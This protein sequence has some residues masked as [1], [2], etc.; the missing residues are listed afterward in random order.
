MIGRSLPAARVAQDPEIADPVLERARDPD[1]IEPPAAVAGRPVGGAIAPPRVDFFR[2]RDALARDVGPLAMG[3][4][5]QKLFAFDRRMRD[6]FQQLPVR[7]HVVFVRR[8]VEVADQDVTV[9]A[10]RTQ[11]VGFHLVE[12]AELV[13]EFRIELWVRY[14]AARG[15]VEIVQHERLG[16]LRL[17]AERNGDMAAIGLVA[18]AADVDVLEW[19]SGDDGNSVIALLAVQCDVLVAQTAETLAWKRVIDAFGFLQAQ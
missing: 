18:E 3:L 11:L 12:K 10:A 5:R 13:L 9:V 1:V 7:P 4:R 16:E 6:D 14:V 15:N 17:L 8:D 19:Q 2:K